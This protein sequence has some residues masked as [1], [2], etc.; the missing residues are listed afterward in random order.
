MAENKELY[1]VDASVM[2]K[3]L[4]HEEND[5]GA[6]LRLQ[7]D[8]FRHK[9]SLAVPS[10]SFYEIMNIVGM[11]SP[12]E[13]LTFLSQLFLFKLEE[14]VLTLSL[15]LKA[16]EVMKKFKGVTFY[17]AIYHALAIKLGGIFITADRKYFEKTKSLKHVQLLKNY[18]K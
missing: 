1:V 11:K 10:H 18:G 2:I 4:L 17:D 7:D 15:T 8:H 14:Y 3:W 16:L 9:I 5:A 12:E 6:A 13:A